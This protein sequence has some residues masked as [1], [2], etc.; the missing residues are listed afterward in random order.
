MKS[1]KCRKSGACTTSE[2]DAKL[3]C[4]DND[5]PTR[6]FLLVRNLTRT[7]T[8]TMQSTLEQLCG[9]WKMKKKY[10]YTQL[11]RMEKAKGTKHTTNA[12]VS[13]EKRNI[14]RW[15]FLK[16]ILC[17]VCESDPDEFSVEYIKLAKHVYVRATHTLS[18][19]PQT[20]TNC[21]IMQARHKLFIMFIEMGKE[22]E[23]AWN[24]HP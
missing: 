14:A 11:K 6:V 9:E 23:F 19:S 7:Y 12:K 17:F 20:R 22:R 3:R 24:I 5:W 16:R 10:I 13:L 15:F 1:G 4:D 18:Q 21:G 2:I 8:R